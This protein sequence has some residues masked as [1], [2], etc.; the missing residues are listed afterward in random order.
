[1][2]VTTQTVH[3]TTLQNN[4]PTDA[5]HMNGDAITQ[6][7]VFQTTKDATGIPTAIMGKMK[8]TVTVSFSNYFKK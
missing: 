2:Q 6:A 5:I 7:N 4:P 1:M 3:P 8:T